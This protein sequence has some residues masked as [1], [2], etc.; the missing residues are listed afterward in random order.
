M[1]TFDSAI[2]R[3]ETDL[4]HVQSS[5]DTAQQVLEVADQAHSA[6]RRL[7]RMIRSSSKTSG[8]ECV[9]ARVQGGQLFHHRVRVLVR[10]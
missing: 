3:A 4:A 6:G 2:T 9:V 5:L 7:V 1:T 8:R 10:H